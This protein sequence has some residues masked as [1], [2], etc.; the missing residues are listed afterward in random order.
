MDKK[1]IPEREKWLY[2]NPEALK[3]VQEGL[4]DAKAGRV[5]KGP[6]S[7][8]DKKGGQDKW[9]LKFLEKSRR[10]RKAGLSLS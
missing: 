2:D 8:R 4:A 7:F 6:K 9:I 10:I 1:D 5:S 3:A